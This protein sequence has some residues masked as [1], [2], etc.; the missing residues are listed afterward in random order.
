MEESAERTPGLQIDRSGN[1]KVPPLDEDSQYKWLIQN[2]KT[3]P[4]WT[5]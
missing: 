2:G 5:R 4:E 1:D 3:H